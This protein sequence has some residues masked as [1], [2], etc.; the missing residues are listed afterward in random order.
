MR[1]I[2]GLL[3]A[4]ILVTALPG[5]YAASVLRQEPPKG[6]LPA[7]ENVLVDNGRCPHGKILQVTGG[8]DHSLRTGNT[9]GGSNRSYK[10]VV[11]PAD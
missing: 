4:G 2:V 7:G 9:R 10:C 8:S 5:A 3:A 11:R 6:K 1:T